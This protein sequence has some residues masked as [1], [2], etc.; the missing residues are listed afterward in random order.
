ML[1]DTYGAVSLDTV[2][3]VDVDIALRTRCFNRCVKS[4]AFKNKITER[5][6]A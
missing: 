4:Q 1:G 3:G 6:D 5:E 2:P